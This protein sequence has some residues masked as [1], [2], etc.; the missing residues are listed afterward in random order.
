VFMN[1][2]D[3]HHTK[4]NLRNNTEGFIDGIQHEE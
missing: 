2:L 3:L 4:P 1:W